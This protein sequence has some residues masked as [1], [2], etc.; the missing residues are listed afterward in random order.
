MNLKLNLTLSRLSSADIGQEYLLTLNDSEYM[1][2]SRNSLLFHDQASQLEYIDSFDGNRS[3]IFGVKS[4]DSNTLVG[5]ATAHINYHNNSID[6]ACLVFR[7]YSG[8]GLGVEIVNL[9]AAYF[10]DKYPRFKMQLST[11]VNNVAMIKTAIKCGFIREVTI[12][13]NDEIVY[14]GKTN[15]QPEALS[16]GIPHFLKVSG[17]ILVVANDA[18]GAEQISELVSHING[19]IY[20]LLT[21]P[22]E[23]I[24]AA[25][26]VRC[27]RINGLHN[28]P[29]VDVALL[30]TGWMS[31]LESSA[32]KYFRSTGVLSV[33]LLDHWVNFRS[34]FDESEEA[35]PNFIAVTNNHAYEVAIQEFS[36][37]P[38]L[39]FPDFQLERYRR[40]LENHKIGSNLLVILEP[41]GFRNGNQEHELSKKLVQDLIT[42]VISL[43]DMTN[44]GNVMLRLH[45]SQIGDK[46]SIAWLKQEFPNI[47]ISDKI[48]VL[49]DFK[50]ARAIYGF[51][52]YALYLSSECRIPTYSVFKANS[53]HWTKK[54]PLIDSVR[55]SN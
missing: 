38:I 46:S 34:R 50:Q 47:N 40:E 44:G 16:F 27:S 19:K 26:N 17:S 10:S 36:T 25:K 53:A 8:N 9:V 49:D 5:T 37:T 15:Q 48:E 23:R 45:P 18:G 32:T 31:D 41:F 24:F 20:A 28:L 11:Q 51:G 7:Q 4:V 43:D 14:F 52:S 54:F 29:K 3:L 35:L 6:I 12:P 1:R 55:L 22:A 30:G 2:F 13:L 39:K 21:G 33:A 42:H